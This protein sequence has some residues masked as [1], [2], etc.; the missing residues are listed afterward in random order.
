MN[1]IGWWRRS[2]KTAGIHMAYT[3]PVEQQTYLKE[4]GQEVD[5]K[6][7]AGLAEVRDRIR[8]YSMH[9]DTLSIV[10]NMTA[11]F[12]AKNPVVECSNPENQETLQA[13][14][15]GMGFQEDL[16]R[17]AREFLVAGE[18]T[19]Y[20]TWDED[21]QCFTREEFL[22]P[23][24][25]KVDPSLTGD[26]W[27]ITVPVPD[28]V[29]AALGAD[30]DDAQEYLK[31]HPQWDTDASEVELP[32]DQVVRVVNEESPWTLRGYPFFTPALSALAQKE[33]LDAALFEEL[34][35]LATPMLVARLGYPAGTMGPNTAG[36]E[37][38]Q[39]QLDS[40]M[41]VLQ[42]LIASKTRV[43]A[44]P[45]GIELKN[46]FN[47][48]HVIELSKYYDR[49]ESSILR[50]VGA[51]KGLIDGSSG[52]PFA[53][54]AVNRDVYTS[55]IESLRV[56]IIR[57]YQKR[58][59]MAVEKLGLVASDVQDG[60]RLAPLLDENGDPIP[61]TAVLTFDNEVMKDSNDKLKTALQLMKEGDVE[62][63]KQKLMDY[64]GLKLDYAQQLREVLKEKKLET[65][66]SKEDGIDTASDG[67]KP[68]SD[69]TKQSDPD[70][71][72]DTDINAATEGKETVSEDTDDTDNETP[73][74]DDS[75]EVKSPNDH[76][77]YE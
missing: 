52:A 13:L 71:D 25:L 60:D 14:F 49:C 50:V 74:D 8:S 70:T 16:Q 66:L 57:A 37:P 36:W 28:S 65:E 45:Y 39:A 68:A 72:T 75:E 9:D 21:E 19:T 64:S 5:L 42:Q 7:D 43:A 69:D 76:R 10:V 20:S 67:E 23:D 47:D 46:A 33:T 58:L 61:E 3:P 32:S 40:W 29:Q 17:M 30:P 77:N 6:S 1:K 35:M 26:G 55:F 51:G 22:D 2:R 27:Q 44:F 56:K 48:A 11:M 62:V 18:C 63:A 53:S 73:S 59:D 54:S 41:Q 12:T 4:A 24:T 31:A 38:T 34:N 15:E